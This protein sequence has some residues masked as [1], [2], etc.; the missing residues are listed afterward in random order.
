MADNPFVPADG[1]FHD[2]PRASITIIDGHVGPSRGN[3]LESDFINFHNDNPIVY[4]DLLGLAMEL[5][6]HGHRKIGMKMLFEVLRWRSM[7]RTT[8]DRFKLNNNY[9]AYYA[10]LIEH[11]VPEM[12]GVF[13][14]R[15]MREG[16]DFDPSVLD[17]SPIVRPNK[18]TS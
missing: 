14:T 10:R 16:F 9:T 12:R 8:G 17:R 15:R 13:D 11:R 6:R 1:A 3:T 7:L 4:L 5:S 2:R 18:E